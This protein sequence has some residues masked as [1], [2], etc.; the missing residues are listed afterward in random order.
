[1]I[2]TFL[3]EEISE[4][5]QIKGRTVRQGDYGSYS[6]ILLDDDLEK[7]QIEKSDIVNLQDGRPITVQCVD[8]STDDGQVTK[9]Y[10]CVYDLLHD[11]R[12]T[13]SETQYEANTKYVQQAKE[14]DDKSQTFLFSLKSGMTE[15]VRTFL[16]EENKGAQ[17]KLSSRTICL[18]DATASM[19]HLLQKSKNTVGTMFERV[20]LILKENNIKENSFEVQFVVY[21]NYNSREDK[22]L[23]H[24]PWDTKPD[25]LRAFMN[26]IDVERGWGNEAIEIGL[27]HANR[28][29]EREKITQIILIGD[30]PPNTKNEV[31]RKREKLGENYWQK[32]KFE[33]ATYYEDELVQLMQNNIPVH[34]FY[35]NNSGKETSFPMLSYLE[36]PP[37]RFLQKLL[38]T[39]GETVRF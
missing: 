13:F 8:I 15:S 5:V 20:S 9:R 12:T 30:A 2:Q 16:I 22:I 34:A 31:K 33:K 26:T 32:T 23:Q 4:E 1:M 7:F 10:E 17:G 14:K 29:H 28:E 24:S 36:T 25:N 35:V 39:P 11:K 38:A 21:R 3:S 27:W 6:M 37:K 18:M 19:S